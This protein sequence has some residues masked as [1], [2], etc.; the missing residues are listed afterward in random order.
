MR[1]GQEEKLVEAIGFAKKHLWP[2]KESFPEEYGS[3]GLLLAYP[4]P[5]AEGLGPDLKH[6]YSLDRWETLAQT[7]TETHNTFLA[8]PSHPLLHIALQVGLS[9]LKT[10]A[11]HSANEGPAAASSASSSVCPICSTELNALAKNVPYAH[12]SQSHVDNDLLLLPNS[13]VYGKSKLEEHAKK[14]GLPS[15]MVKDLRTG[16]VFPVDTLKKVFI[17]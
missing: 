13:R 1:Q 2:L 10:P 7:F 4:P 16:E 14:S 17:T 11:C 15:K 12:H 9:A 5:Q 3:A 8:L 6:L